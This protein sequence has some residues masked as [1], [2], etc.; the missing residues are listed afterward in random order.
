MTTHIVVAQIIKTQTKILR[1]KLK[2]INAKWLATDSYLYI[3]HK[4]VIVP[5]RI[6]RLRL[7]KFLFHPPLYF[8]LL[9]VLKVCTTTAQPLFLTGVTAGIKSVCHHA[10][11][12][13]L[14]YTTRDLPRDSTVHNELG[15]PT[16]IYQLLTKKMPHRHAYSI[17]S[18]EIPSSQVIL[19]CAK[20]IKSN[21]HNP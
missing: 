14:S 2:F 16:S 8:S 20:L 10:C 6:L 15:P 19:D 13:Q 18:L 11:L 21:Q 17:F 4:W 5:P 9:L 3:W 7:S 12:S 1:C